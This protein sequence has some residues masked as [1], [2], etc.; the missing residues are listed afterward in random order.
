MFVLV[1]VGVA[2]YFV[3]TY[4]P[5]SPPFKL[6]IRVVVVL[7]LVLWLLSVFGILHGTGVHL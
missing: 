1:I 3:E 6:A 4:I 7:A 2:L 5:L